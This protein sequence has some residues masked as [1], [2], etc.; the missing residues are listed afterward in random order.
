MA[1]NVENQPGTSQY[2]STK[3]GRKIEFP[4][5]TPRGHNKNPSTPGSR[6]LLPSRRRA[7]IA[8]NQEPEFEGLLK[9]GWRVHTLSPL[10]NFKGHR[11]FLI[12]CERSL[13]A[14]LSQAQSTSADPLNS[15]TEKSSFSFYDDLKFHPDDP[16]ALRIQVHERLD[17]GV[18]A[19]LVMEA[20]LVC[21]EPSTAPFS[22]WL[23]EHFTYYPVM[24]VSGNKARS[25]VLLEWLERHYDCRSDVLTLSDSDLK[26]MLVLSSAFLP[27][28]TKGPPVLMQYSL[29]DVCEGISVINCKLETHYCKQLWER[30]FS[31]SGA[32]KTEIL[33]DEVDMFVSHIE[34]LLEH[35]MNI[36]FKKLNLSE[37]GTPA[38]Y[39]SHLGKIKIFSPAAVY[40]ALHHLCETANNRFLELMPRE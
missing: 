18:M 7:S 16:P 30:L 15:G 39:V 35:M 25:T 37:V 27:A 29:E 32:V 24:L 36:F 34:D 21:V 4:L 5:Y 12:K 23:K 8:S 26:Y 9:K 13:D 10:Y 2:S 17:S 1:T 33:K 38:A 20:F 40:T 22:P 31:S 11:S 14:A 19:K 28:N 6:R 3:K